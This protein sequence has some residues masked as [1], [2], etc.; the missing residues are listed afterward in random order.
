MDRGRMG[1]RPRP[2]ARRSS[3]ADE[4]RRSSSAEEERLAAGRWP[5][6]SR[7]SLRKE[8]NGPSKAT[9]DRAFKNRAAQSLGVR[10]GFERG[11]RPR[12]A[13]SPRHA[14]GQNV[15]G[16]VCRG[17]RRAARQAFGG[18]ERVKDDVRD[19]C[20]RPGTR[21]AQRTSATACGSRA[22]WL[23]ARRSS[24]RSRSASASTPRSS[25]YALC[26][27]RCPFDRRSDW[28]SCSTAPLAGQRVPFS[29]SELDDYRKSLGCSTRSP[30]S[31]RCGSSCSA[32][33]AASPER[34][35]TGVVSP[36]YFRC[37]ASSRSLGRSRRRRRAAR[38]AGGAAA[39]P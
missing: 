15:R 35:S 31:T 6:P 5:A 26:C 2:T 37:S 33:Q 21:S 24:S 19:A 25:A 18:V 7:A 23:R 12:A 8:W 1:T 34:V 16:H 11:A 3:I 30:S 29:H 17:R 28:S 4:G 38:R 22:A 32:A 14:D 13:V 20:A 27:G 36:N 39:H 9:F 10:G